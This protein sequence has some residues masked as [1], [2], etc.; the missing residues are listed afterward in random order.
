MEARSLFNAGVVSPEMAEA[1]AMKEALSLIKT[2]TWEP[3]VVEADCLAVVQ[4]VVEY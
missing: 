2:H 4:A 3:V 1:I